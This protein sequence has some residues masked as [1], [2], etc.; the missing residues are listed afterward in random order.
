MSRPSESVRTL[1]YALCLVG[2]WLFPLW[3]VGALVVVKALSGA[4]ASW[5]KRAMYVMLLVVP[6]LLLCFI[7]AMCGVAAQHA[8]RPTS[9]RSSIAF[10]DDMMIASTITLVAYGVA[11]GLF[12]AFADLTFLST[13][14]ADLSEPVRLRGVVLGCGLGALFT[15]NPLISVIAIPIVLR[16]FAFRT[17]TKWLGILACV[18]GWL[19]I[20]TLIV[21]ASMEDSLYIFETC[22]GEC[23]G[24]Y[25]QRRDPLFLGLWFG[26]TV[27][28][29]LLLICSA[30][31]HAILL[32]AFVALADK[33]I[34]GGVASVSATSSDDLRL[35]HACPQCQTVVQFAPDA[36]G[37]TRVECFACHAIVEFSH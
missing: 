34:L 32:V 26:S 7:A 11:G 35:A 17:A 33:A 25:E 1:L 4:P 9:Y 18:T 36:S 27:A 37:T 24:H 20:I 13:R 29:P 16:R 30:A 5:H 23:L 6:T 12:V 10:G 28:L 22:V 19:T 31:L 3:L 21:S 15:F 14:G 2:L 8:S